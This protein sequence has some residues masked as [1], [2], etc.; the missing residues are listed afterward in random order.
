MIITIVSCNTDEQKAKAL[1]NQAN[2]FYEQQEWASARMIIDSLK[3]TYPKELS[4]LQLAFRLSQKIE[5]T[6][7]K[8]NLAF[9]DSILAVL[10]QESEKMK[11]KFNYEKV[12]PYDEIGKYT[13]KRWVF[14]RNIKRTYIRSGVNE[15]G[16]MYMASVYHGASPIHHTQ[17]KVSLPGAGDYAITE[18]IPSDNALNYSF[19]DNGMTTEMITYQNG[20]D[21]GVIHFICD[22]AEKKLTAE[23]IGKKNTTIVIESVDKEVM[24]DVKNFAT[25]LTEI[26]RV[27]KEMIRLN[28]RIAYLEAHL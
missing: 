3:A 20:R 22:H 17:L 16:E 21:N 6:E 5:L 9:C 18:L 14:E 11:S 25:I 12:E 7:S 1:L 27:K 10:Q 13:S 28:G 8:R 19:T 26:I 4:S 2:D 23:F 24:C 15:N